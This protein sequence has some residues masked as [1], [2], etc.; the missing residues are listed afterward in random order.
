[1]V[2][3]DSPKVHILSGDLNRH[4][5]TLEPLKT[6]IYALRRYDRERYLA[7]ESSEYDMAK[8]RGDN[9]QKPEVKHTGSDN[10]DPVIPNDWEG[11]MSYRTRIYLVSASLLDGLP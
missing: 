3:I 10:P 4:K 2:P 1:M 5:R 8:G 11:Y 9:V 6:L 7:A